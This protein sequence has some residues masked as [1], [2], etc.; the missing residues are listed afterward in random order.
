MPLLVRL[1][2]LATALLGVAAVAPAQAAAALSLTAGSPLVADANNDGVIAPGDTLSIA[3]PVTNNGADAAGLQ[4]TLSSSTPGVHVVAGKGSSSYPDI[5]A[6]NTASNTTPFQVTVD[7]QT[8]VLCGT[9]LNFTLTFTSDSGP[10][11]VLFAVPTG[12]MGQFTDYSGGSAVIGDALPTMY[13]A[14]TPGSY[15]AAAT[16]GTAGI[17]DAVRVHIVKLTHPD[18]GQLKLELV[19]PDG[20]GAI[21]ATLIDHQGSPG[22][23]FEN[24]DLVQSGSPLASPFTGTFQADGNLGALLNL[25]QEGTWHLAITADDHTALGHLDGWTLQIAKADCSPRS[26]ADLQVPVRADPG[27]VQLDASQST[28]IDGGGITQY[29]WDFG[30]G[31]FTQSTVAPTT[32]KVTHTFA[33]GQYTVRVR[34][35]DANGVIGTA[36]KQLIVSLAPVAVI[37]PLA[38]DPKQGVNVVLDGSQSSD[39]DHAGLSAHEWDLDYDGV[40]FSADATGDHPTV[41]FPTAGARTIALRVTD[42]DGA[43]TIAPMAV[44]VIPTSAPTARAVATPNPAVA[45]TPVSF[46]ASSSSDSDGTVVAYAWDLDG[47]GSFETSGGSSPLASRSYPNAGVVSVGLRVTDNDGKT[48]TTHVSV[49]VKLAPGAGGSQGSSGG[50]SGG[51]GGGGAAGP[52]SGGGGTTSGGGDASAKLS[53]KLAGASIQ[54]LKLVKKKGLGLSCSAD[55]AAKCSVT[56]TLRAADARRLKLSKSRKK[57]YVLGRASVSLKKAGAAKITVRLASKALAKLAKAGR[58]TVLVNGT[59]V[60]SGGGKA[61]LRRAVLLRR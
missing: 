31:A 37:Q 52:G 14:L 60:D 7:D 2:V 47:N 24:T 8:V 30:S 49:L 45:G 43:T 55:R 23:S 42:V 11:T 1:M 19:A 33:R 16:V 41:Q 35:S 53:A 18:V 6:G 46:D 34:V 29:D 15:S 58:I 44:N 57:D 10:A 56:V 3:V 28:T 22:D 27:A 40:S 61:A 36:T 17:I 54:T 25:H 5:L 26:Y 48:A 59:A 13:P 51:G 38:T 4:A 21:R 12:A 32:G 50:G 9:T 39:P 20:A